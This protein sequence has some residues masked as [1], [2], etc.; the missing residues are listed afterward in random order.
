[1]PPS[2]VRASGRL[3]GLP[4]LAGL[5]ADL[6]GLPV[7]VVAE[8]EAGLRGAA[9]LAALV[10]GAGEGSLAS[11]PPLR[12]RREPRWPEARRVRVRARWRAFVDA[13]AALP[14]APS[15]GH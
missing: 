6:S 15:Q 11:A 1:V 2:V 4:A 8:E 3:A 5:V 7:E 14:A 10:L 12:G 9:R 13:A